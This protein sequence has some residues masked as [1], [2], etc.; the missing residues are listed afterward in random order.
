M[1]VPLHKLRLRERGYNQSGL[2]ARALGRLIS[3]PVVDGCL[4]RSKDSLPQ[5]KAR[6]VEERRRNVVDAFAC[7]DR[8]LSGMNV[9]LIDDVCT[10]GSTLG[11]CAT[12]LKATGTVSVWGL[13][14]ARE[15]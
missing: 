5:T 4:F 12:A 15:V 10:S 1:P 13:T 9:L 14:I 8:R 2:L 7:R 11:A 3:L 6:T